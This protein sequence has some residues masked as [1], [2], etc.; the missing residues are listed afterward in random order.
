MKIRNFK[1]HSDL[2]LEF[3]NG[4]NG[5]F[6]SNGVG[7]TNILD[8][9]YFLGNGRSYFSRQDLHSIPFE[10]EEAYWDG[11]FLNGEHSDIHAIRLEQSGTKIIHRNGS[12]VS[13]LADLITYFPMVMIT[14]SDIGI[15][16]GHS[17]VR[18]KLIDRTIS[19]TDS[20]YLRSLQR[21]QKL[22][23]FRNEMLKRFSVSGKQDTVALE[24]IDRQIFPEAAVI[25]KARKGFI[26]ELSQQIETYYLEISDA[27]E[28]C[29][30]EY[31]SECHSDSLSAIFERNLRTDILAQR[32]T[33]GLHKDDLMIALDSMDIRKYG[34]QGQVKSMAV[35]IQLAVFRFLEIHCGKT[36]ILLLDD[37]YEKIDDHRADRLMKLIS[38]N[39]FGQIFIT[40][41]SEARLRSRLEGMSPDKKFFNIERPTKGRKK[42]VQN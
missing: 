3:V 25:Y 24:S 16:N 30:I 13:R 29:G 28:S 34:S 27:V 9:I 41:T 2:D 33:S 32:T 15:I 39:S 37:I 21:Y 23:A 31:E 26:S 40:D 7:K 4:F 11:E 22:I 19:L 38:G 20:G 5:I 35:A 14:P 17:E 1:N 12:Q 18:R 42:R 10:N 8:A 6:G 36:P